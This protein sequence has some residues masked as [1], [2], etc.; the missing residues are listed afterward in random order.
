MSNTVKLSAALPANEDFNGL[1]DEHDELLKDPTQL[2]A[3]IV[4]YDVPKI[5]T[6]TD[7]GLVQ[8]HVRLRKFEPMSP[9]QDTDPRVRDLVEKAI[10]Q[11]TGR[12]PLPLEDVDEEDEPEL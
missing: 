3:A 1:D 9:I 10:T 5:V 2:R 11:R 12:T 8:P 6:N 4:V 7:T